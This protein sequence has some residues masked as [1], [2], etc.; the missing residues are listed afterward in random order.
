MTNTTEIEP[1]SFVTL[2][3][4]EALCSMVL[5][6]GYAPKGSFAEVGVYQGGSAAVLY[7]LAERQGRNLH[8]FDTWEGMP[9]CGENDDLPVG[10]F[11]DVD[12]PKLKREMPRAK[13]YQGIFP[14]TMPK[15]LEPLAFVHVDCDQYQSILDSIDYLFPLLVDGGVMLFDDWTHLPGAQKAIMQRFNQAR[16]TPQGKPFVI[17]GVS[18]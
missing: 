11:A 5:L 12:L 14:E 1:G 17:K 3:S 16:M 6:A 10:C 9:F 7:E 4:I 18:S 15:Y 2:V 13:F 8:L